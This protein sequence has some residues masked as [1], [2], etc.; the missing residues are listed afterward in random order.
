[1]YETMFGIE[2]SRSMAQHVS[3]A[4]SEP[5]QQMALNDKEL[6]VLQQMIATPG[7]EVLDRLYNEASR[8]KVLAAWKEIS[9]IG[10]GDGNASWGSSG[11]GAAPE[12]SKA[13]EK[14][15]PHRGSGAVQQL[16][17][18]TSSPSAAAHQR[19]LYPVRRVGTGE[20]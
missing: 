4:D 20:Y 1:M 2:K 19:Q 17:H 5:D 3:S 7:P 9:G 12:S 11:G 6:A 13:A 18:L 15:S 14:R 16:P 10:D 8:R